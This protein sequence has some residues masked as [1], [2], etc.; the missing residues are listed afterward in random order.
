MKLPRRQK[1]VVCVL[2]FLFPP[3]FL[4]SYL[5]IIMLDAGNE[6]AEAAKKGS[7]CVFFL[8]FLFLFSYLPIIMLDAGNEVAEAAKQGSMC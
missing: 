1:K 6:A 5:P 7:R 4:F 3:F 8:F 2:F